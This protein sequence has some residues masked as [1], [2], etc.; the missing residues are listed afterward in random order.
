MEGDRQAPEGFYTVTPGADEPEFELLPV[1]QHRLSQHLSTAA[2]GRT[3]SNLMVHGACSSAGCY[4]M[5]DEDAGEIFSL[6]RDAFHGGQRAFQIQAFPFRMTAENLAKHRDDPNMDF[7]RM[8]KVG[9]DTFELTRV[10]PKVDVC[11][12]RYVFNADAGGASFKPPAP[13]RPMRCRRSWPTRCSASRPQDD[14]KFIAGRRH[15]RAEAGGRGG[16]PEGGGRTGGQS[17]RS[18]SAC[19]VPGRRRP[20][21]APA[22]PV[23]PPK[24]AVS[25]APAPE[26]CAV[27]TPKAG[28]GAGLRWRPSRR[29]PEP[30]P[31]SGTRPA[32]SLL[33]SEAAAP[34]AF[35]CREPAARQ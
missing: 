5:T 12:K 35:G 17:G 8:L 15:A 3:G 26:G 13:A 28:A 29:S 6:A 20:L 27:P 34:V 31:R 18:S 11:D 32:S 24:A 23:A 2:L 16:A 22:T 33:R 25:V 19:S 10:P 7:W 30:T 21:P 9:Y 1:V 4:S 14:A